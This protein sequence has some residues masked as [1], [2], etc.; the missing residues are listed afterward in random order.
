MSRFT[1]GKA[2]HEGNPQTM[3]LITFHDGDVRIENVSVLSHKVGRRFNRIELDEQDLY[4]LCQL[5]PESLRE[6]A[7]IWM[8]GFPPPRHGDLDPRP[9]MKP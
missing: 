9:E 1:D 7:H 4:Q 2:L 5:R 6:W 8:C 3:K